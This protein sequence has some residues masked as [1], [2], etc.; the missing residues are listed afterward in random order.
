[1][2]A[3]GLKNRQPDAVELGDVGHARD[4]G[5]RQQGL[6]A[7]P[8]LFS[9]AAAVRA[10]TEHFVIRLNLITVGWFKQRTQTVCLE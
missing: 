2:G 9:C 5:L 8:G 7:L 10:L 4:P 1:V 6:Q 3:N